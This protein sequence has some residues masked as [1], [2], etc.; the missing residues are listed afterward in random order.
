[1]RGHY[2]GFSAYLFNQ[3]I[4]FMNFFMFPLILIIFVRGE[5]FKSM[6]G[7][8]FLQ[9]STLVMQILAFAVMINS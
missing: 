3:S 1:M 6:D 4:K 9:K 8:D 2:Q 5:I 7:V